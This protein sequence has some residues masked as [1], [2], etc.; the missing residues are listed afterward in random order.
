MFI[1]FQTL[2]VFD[3]G[4]WVSWLE[5]QRLRLRHFT[6]GIGLRRLWSRVVWYSRGS[7]AQSEAQASQ[8]RANNIPRY[9]FFASWYILCLIGTLGSKAWATNGM[10]CPRCQTCCWTALALS[11][12]QPFSAGGTCRLR[13]PATCLMQ[14]ATMCY[15]SVLQSLPRNHLFIFIC[16]KVIARKLGFD[17]S[18]ETS[19]WKDRALLEMNAAILHSFRVSLSILDLIH[20]S[21]LSCLPSLPW[22]LSHNIG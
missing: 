14:A 10:P 22:N 5:R 8:V 7:R 9:S 1:W 4:L 15:Q 3:Q 21:T 6:T 19:L 12:L 16:L 13:L 11:S 2:V 18:D 20:Y 17:T